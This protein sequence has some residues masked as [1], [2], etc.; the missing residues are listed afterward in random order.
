MRIFISLNNADVIQK[1][2]E[3]QT[4]GPIVLTT[5]TER[6]D[7]GTNYSISW[8]NKM[9]NIE[10][11]LVKL[12]KDSYIVENKAPKTPAVVYSY[13]DLR[14]AVM[15][16][17]VNIDLSRLSETLSDKLKKIVGEKVKLYE[18]VRSLQVNL[19]PTIR[20]EHKALNKPVLVGARKDQR[21]IMVGINWS[22]SRAK[23]ALLDA[24][25]HPTRIV[26]LDTELIWLP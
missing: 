23:V 24:K 10:T 2:R 8:L 11:R 15:T 25:G 9:T 19:R 20:K 4:S 16:Y 7:T 26:E 5:E 17:F 1:T 12:G 14:D 6:A 21:G 18:N 22:G 3:S 13:T